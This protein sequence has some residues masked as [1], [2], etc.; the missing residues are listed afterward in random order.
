MLL[1]ARMA[2]SQTTFP[3]FL[4]GTWKIKNQEVYEHWNQLNNQL[5]KGVSYRI[6]DGKMD[7]SE[8]LDVSEANG[9][10]TYTATVIGQNDGKGVEFRLIRSDD[11]FVFSNP[12]HD[13]PKKIAYKQLSETELQVTISGEEGKEITYV[14]NKQEN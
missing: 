12:G 2:V 11:V 4:N 14:M 1:F 10:I 7:V 9:H 5:L 13:F 6:S 3:V 8:Y